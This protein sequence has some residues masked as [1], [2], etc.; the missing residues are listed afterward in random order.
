MTTFPDL[1][2]MADT[3]G[4]TLTKHTEGPPGFY[5]HHNKVIS[6]RHG[7]SPAMYR[8]ALAHELGHAMYRDHPTHNGHFDQKQERRADRFAAR[9]LINPQSFPHDFVW[10]QGCIAELADELEVSQHLLK[11]FIHANP[12]IL[13]ELAA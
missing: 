8:S 9:L 6:T 7:L 12:H 1:A 4:V 13:K 11:V 10:C 5:D 2:I 3:L